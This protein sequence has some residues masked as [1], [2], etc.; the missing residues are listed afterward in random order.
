[1]SKNV[2]VIMSDEHDPRHSGCYGSAF[3]KT[4]NIDRLAARGLRF[5]NA[6]TPCPICVPARAAFATGQRVH[7]ARLWDNALP[8]YGQF[9]SWGHVLQEQNIRVESV[10]KLHYRA[11]GDAAGFDSEHIPMHVHGGVG[12]VWGS[13]RDPYLK[14]FGNQRML[15]EK[16]GVGESS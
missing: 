9:R 14:R 5:A 15:G 4:P 13:I 7:Q 10:G 1:M 6:Y 12:M 8:Y 11:E 16:I 2:I 3:V